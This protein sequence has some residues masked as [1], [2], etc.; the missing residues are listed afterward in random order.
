MTATVD[1]T[2]AG[3]SK[4]YEFAKHGVTAAANSEIVS[5]AG[6]FAS[7]CKAKLW[8]AIGK[9]LSNDK[10]KEESKVEEELVWNT[11]DHQN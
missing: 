4:S 1:I 10:K 7:A 9:T 5:K 2:K 11:R 8:G 6:V 3:A